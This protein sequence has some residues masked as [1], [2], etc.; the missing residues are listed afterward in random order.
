MSKLGKGDKAVGVFGYTKCRC[1]HTKAVHLIGDRRDGD[2]CYGLEE[3][4]KGRRPPWNERSCSCAGYRTAWPRRSGSADCIE[5]GIQFKWKGRERNFCPKCERRCPHCR[6]YSRGGTHCDNCGK[7]RGLSIDEFVAE[8]PPLS[9]RQLNTIAQLLSIG[10]ERQYVVGS[11]RCG[12][13]GK[14]T[15]HYRPSL[16]DGCFEQRHGF[17]RKT[18]HRID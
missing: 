15:A 18:S 11:P 16:C 12:Q 8:A 6:S 2:G 1:G 13:C 7:H 9:G 14:P 5:C 10:G 17:Q 3:L 4:P